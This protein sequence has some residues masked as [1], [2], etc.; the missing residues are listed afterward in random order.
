[1]PPRVSASPSAQSS[2]GKDHQRPPFC[3]GLI[4]HLNPPI[5]LGGHY[6]S[7][8]PTQNAFTLPLHSVQNPH[9][10]HWLLLCLLCYSVLVIP[11]SL[12]LEEPAWP[13]CLVPLTS[14][15]LSTFIAKNNLCRL[16][17]SHLYL[18]LCLLFLNFRLQIPQHNSYPHYQAGK[19]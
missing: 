2:S 19:T 18:Q 10:P 3:W 16:I 13:Q 7:F 15:S 1:M 6:R 12:M 17:L 11:A 8:P 14:T 9:S 4:S 5:G